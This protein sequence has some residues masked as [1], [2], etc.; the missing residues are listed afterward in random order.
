M[1][2]STNANVALDISPLV[3]KQRYIE[4]RM[5]SKKVMVERLK[6]NFQ[7]SMFTDVI[8]QNAEQDGDWRSDYEMVVKSPIVKTEPIDPLEYFEVRQKWMGCVQEV[9]ADC[10]VAHLTPLTGDDGEHI[11]EIFLEELDKEDR[12]DLAPG[13]YFYWSIG[14]I[15]RPSGI[16]RSSLIR[17]RRLP[18]WQE[19]EI[20]RAK[21]EADKLATIFDE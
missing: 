19:E 13:S 2:S 7:G 11:A 9:Q 1:N 18:L 12:S 21:V 20:Q 4:K 15:K 14:Y 3:P 6:D 17:L 5:D 10:F 16:V 8:G